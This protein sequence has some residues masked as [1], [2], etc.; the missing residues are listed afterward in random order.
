MTWCKTKFSTNV[1]LSGE[2]LVM[3]VISGKF[4]FAARV[5]N[6]LFID[7]FAYLPQFVDCTEHPQQPSAKDTGKDVVGLVA[8][9][10]SNQGPK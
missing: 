5:Q 1:T 3:I 7:C 8:E 9:I 2:V 6:R 4:L 10:V